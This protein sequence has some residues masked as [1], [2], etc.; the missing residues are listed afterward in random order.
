MSC[1]TVTLILRQEV[2][3]ARANRWFL[4]F[5]TIFAGMALGLSILGMAGLGNFGIAGFG[6]TAASLLNLVVV[7]VPLMAL[8]IGATSIVGEREQ[9]TLGYLL[10][11]P[12]TAAELL[13]GKFLGLGLVLL[14]AV[15]GGFGLSALVIG[16]YGGGSQATEYAL[17]V[18]VTC[19][20]AIAYLSLGYLISTLFSKTP[21][22]LGVGLFVWLISV[23]ICDL[24]LMG[25]A[26]VL[27]VSPRT[28]LWLSLINPAQ[29]Y[30]LLV[31]YLIQG[32]LESLGPA[33]M[34]AADVFGPWLWPTL[35][36]VLAAWIVVP[37]MTVLLMF[38]GKGML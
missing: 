9:G 10:A 18:A 23:L 13:L 19:L 22:A 16:Y 36:V 14:A 11:Q 34:Y 7:V 4:V 6:R 30:K 31:L 24:G 25:T 1:R 8:A 5:A 15:L 32:N 26:V 3:D 2:R 37:L 28:L 33:G 20:F 35:A 29:V 17:L 21:T 12:I 38:R 27:Q